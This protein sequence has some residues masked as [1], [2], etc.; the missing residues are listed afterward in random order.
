MFPFITK[1]KAYTK[2]NTF[3]KIFGVSAL[4]T[5]LD[6]FDVYND[7]LA[8][9][10]DTNDYVSIR[11][12]YITLMS[13]SKIGKIFWAKGFTSKIDHKIDNLSFSSDGALL[14]AHSGW[15]PNKNFIVVLNV[16]TGNVVSARYY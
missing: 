12:P 9:G 11:T 1:I 14:I 13:I 7:Y 5:H 2:C 8:F 15:T 4:S 16:E 6:G 10:S 3:P